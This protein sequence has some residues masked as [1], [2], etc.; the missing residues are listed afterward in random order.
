MSFLDLDESLLELAQKVDLVFSPIIDIKEYPHNVDACLVEGA[1]CNE[2]HLETAHK[3]R[4]RTR[5]VISFGDCAVTGNVS[6]IRNQL[7]LRNVENV[8]QRAYIESVDLNQ[9]FPVDPGIVLTLLERVMPL[10][11]VIHVDLYLPGCPPP[12]PRIKSFLLQLLEG[13]EPVLTGTDIKFG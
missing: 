2:E 13:K 1:V 6:A 4:E 9:E 3:I 11:E 12:A 10:H 7:G 5:Y 8:L